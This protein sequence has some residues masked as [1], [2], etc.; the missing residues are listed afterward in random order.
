M[1]P[2]CRVDVIHHIACRHQIE[3]EVWPPRIDLYFAD[4]RMAVDHNGALVQRE[5]DLIDTQAR[6]EA[7]VINS[8][9]GVH[10]QVFDAKGG[11]GAG[12][13]DATGLYLAPGKGAWQ[14]GHTDVVVATSVEDPLR[15]AYA[16][17]T[18]IGDGPLPAP[19]ARIEIW[20][21]RV[22]LYYHE[23]GTAVHNNYIDDSNKAQLF[24]ARIW[25]SD[26]QSATWKIFSGPGSIDFN[27]GLYVAPYSGNDHQVVVVR[28]YIGATA[29]H[30]EARIVLRD[31]VWPGL[32]Y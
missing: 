2:A 12:S 11:P 9:R 24:Q 20:P 6:F 32:I 27:T 18:L 15:K 10:W 21:K 1:R 8:D 30:D 25:N 16:W 23:A 26:I 31:Y 13:I 5:V 17:V 29:I 7:T 4:A 28:G 19:E 14:S 3:I 22:D